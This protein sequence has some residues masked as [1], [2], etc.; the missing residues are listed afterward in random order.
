M[1]LLSVNNEETP[2]EQLRYITGVGVRGHVVVQ[3]YF[4]V[5]F[6]FSHCFKLII[7][8]YQAQD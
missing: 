5:Q 4:W 8:D 3:L 6:Y 7:I 1:L 2:Y